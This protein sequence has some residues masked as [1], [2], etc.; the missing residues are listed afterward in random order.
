MSDQK[1]LHYDA[2]ISYRHNEFDSFVAENLHKKL[3][4]FKLPKSV[5]SK[6]RSGKKRIER[7]FRDVDELPLTDNLSDPITTALQNSDFLITICTP[8]YLESKWCMKEIE[9]FLQS[10]PRDH[11]LVVLA[12][13]E[14]VNSFPKILCYEEVRS[15]NDRG[16]I[17]I[18][19]RELEPLAADTRGD[20]KKE[21]LKAMDTAVIKLCAA[22]FGLNYDDLKQRHRAQK[23]RRLSMIFGSIGAALLIFAIF[24]TIMLIKISS[25]NRQLRYDLA[26]TMA[27]TADNL[28]A[29]GRNKDA[30]YAVRGALPDDGTDY[31]EKALR[32]LYQDMGVYK[33]SDMY[34][35][36]CTYDVGSWVESFDILHDGQD[37]LVAESDAAYVFDIESCDTVHEILSPY[38][39]GLQA[40]LFGEGVLWSTHLGSNF[41]SFDSGQ[42]TEMELTDFARAYHNDDGSLAIVSDEGN[43]YGMDGFGNLLYTI[44]LNDIFTY[45]E[46]ELADV[47][48]N[49]DE[50]LCCFGG[51]EGWGYLSF[52]P[53][54][55]DI[56]SLYEKKDESI[57]EPVFGYND[58]ILYAAISGETD[59]G[60][61]VR[62]Y[63]NDVE[64]GDIS[65]KLSIDDLEMEI[66]DAYDFENGNQRILVTE[67]FIYFYGAYEVA[68]IDPILEEIVSR[69]SY[70]EYIMEAWIMNDEMYFISNYGK[71]FTCS[72]SYG[73]QEVTDT[74]FTK[75]T[76]Q[77]I[78]TAR[79]INGELYIL[80][81]NASYVIRYSN[82]ISPFAEAVDGEYEETSVELYFP[83]QVFGDE[84]LYDFN[85]D[86]VSEVA[87]YSDDEKY[88]FGL[89]N[90]HTAKIFDARTG[91]LITSFETTEEHFN[92]LRYCDLTGSYILSG[93]KSYIFD[94]DMRI[95]CIMD[96]IVCVEDDYFIMYSNEYG[97]IRIP[98][99]DYSG[100][101]DLADDYLGDYEPPYTVKQKYGLN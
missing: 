59:E 31:N 47:F 56:I 74:F 85:I 79:F 65:W 55:G 95:I 72:G 76:V 14:P 71:V 37:I 11:V 18:T 43:L 70:N 80:F 15:R 33:A 13:D 50:V 36:V 39:N 35:P 101:C 62:V 2:F 40:D 94:K 25:Q 98:Y 32:A 89:F 99:I 5:L 86:L 30:V 93:E 42:N 45:E 69:Y 88:S 73:Q 12:E 90:D 49:Q 51:Y 87:F 68:V 20:N 26:T 84:E 82:S 81:L 44:Y 61:R 60:S 58:G 46:P 83:D 96:R 91:E 66:V 64:S 75:K 34:A 7:V 92:D 28:C 21:V 67:E 57:Y 100:L 19:R 22:I 23:I 29:D 3:E 97:Y 38:P 1:G 24:A 54:N 6:V 48:W 78:K 8:R 63:A 16:E 52:D 27:N 17:V 10:H 77:Y 9:V 4:N 41:Y 53:Q